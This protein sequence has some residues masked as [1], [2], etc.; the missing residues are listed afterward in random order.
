MS[1]MNWYERIA[2]GLIAV[3]IFVALVEALSPIS[4]W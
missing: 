3:I 1:D 2:W 4:H